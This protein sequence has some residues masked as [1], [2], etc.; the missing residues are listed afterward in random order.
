MA[1]IAACLSMAATIASKVAAQHAVSV[2][3]GQLRVVL[4]QRIAELAAMDD[5]AQ[6]AANSTE[7]AR[8]EDRRGPSGAA[9]N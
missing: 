3:D 7:N 6:S 2:R 9:A 8:K 1:A 5:A 4:G